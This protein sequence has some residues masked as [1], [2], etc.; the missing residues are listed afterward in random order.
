MVFRIPLKNFSCTKYTVKM[1]DKQRCIVQLTSWNRIILPVFNVLLN[2]QAM[3]STTAVFYSRVIKYRITPR[4]G[5]YSES[6]DPTLNFNTVL[7]R[8]R[9]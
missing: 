1:N 4:S 8:T 2:T 5:C 9:C 3:R 7:T 6:F